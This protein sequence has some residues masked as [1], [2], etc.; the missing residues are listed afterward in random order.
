[1]EKRVT[2]A[3]LF[4][5]V[6]FVFAVTQVSHL[7]HDDHS[8]AGVG[9]ALIVFVPVY[10]TWVGTSVHAN[11]HD[12]DNPL[13]RIGV[14]GI[15]LASLFMALALPY[16]YDDRG[17]LLGAA[18]WGARLILA[19]LVFRGWR[20]I[21][22]NTFSVS[23]V[24]TG[25]LMLAGGLVDGPARIVLWTLAA[26]IDLLTPR[27]VRRR[28]AM[29]K[30]E[31]HHLPERFGLFQIIA[32]GEAVVAVG[33]VAAGESLTSARL[34]AVAASFALACGLWWVYFSYAADG[35]RHA[36]ETAEVQTDVIRTV[37]AYGHL[38]FI[39]GVIAVAVGLAEVVSHPGE[40]L[41][42]DSAALLFGGTALYLGT[43]GYTRW[44]MFR[45]PGWG[46]VIAAVV[47]LALMPLGVLLPAVVALLVLVLVPV[48]LNVAE[49]VAVNRRAAPAAA[50]AD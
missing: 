6:V 16:A 7:L 37:L 4:F 46:R 38:F 25:P 36:L 34:L 29:I 5:D 28:L 27:L 50:Q 49:A 30:F 32:L 22:I 31:P 41:H 19:A 33:G 1:M 14:F 35:I 2:W 8:W 12:V 17:A 20:N 39:G 21:P 10:W 13:D 40:H 43:F 42:T 11:T 47:A 26:A 24:L 48:V 15:G 44:R 3:E 18:Y 45:V 9:Q 23:A